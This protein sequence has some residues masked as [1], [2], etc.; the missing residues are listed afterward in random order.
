MQPARFILR[1]DQRNRLQ[2][3][4]KPHLAQRVVLEHPQYL[5]DIGIDRTVQYVLAV[6]TPREVEREIT[7]GATVER[8]EVYCVAG[9]VDE[10]SRLVPRGEDE[11][12]VAREEDGTRFGAGV[13]KC[14]WADVGDVLR[15]WAATV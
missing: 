5:P 3:R 10:D 9:E 12:G 14:W 7:A 15:H 13:E 6:R 4:H 2:V 8:I 11:L 1:L